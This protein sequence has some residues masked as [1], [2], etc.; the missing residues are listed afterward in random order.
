MIVS[1]KVAVYCWDTVNIFSFGIT[2]KVRSKQSKWQ[3]MKSSDQHQLVRAQTKGL[4]WKNTDK[5]SLLTVTQYQ[6]RDQIYLIINMC[7]WLFIFVVI[8]DNTDWDHL[9]CTHYVKDKPKQ[10]RDIRQTCSH[11]HNQS[12]HKIICNKYIFNIKLCIKNKIKQC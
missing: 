7:C 9:K 5:Q 8:K 2:V 6:I 10:S 1:D 12:H 4:F 3:K 11:L